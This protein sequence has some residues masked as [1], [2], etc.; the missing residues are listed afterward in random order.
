MSDDAAIDTDDLAVDPVPLRAGQES[1]RVGER[2]EV[3]AS[4]ALLLALY[5]PWAGK[6]R[7]TTDVEKVIN[8]SPGRSRRDAC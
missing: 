1:D 4:T 5:A 6:A 3:S 2:V 8:A 7:P